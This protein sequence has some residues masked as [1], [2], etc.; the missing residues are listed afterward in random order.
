MYNASPC[1]LPAEPYDGQS[2][3]DIMHHDLWV[4][5][6]VPSAANEVDGGPWM[7]GSVERHARHI[8]IHAVIPQLRFARGLQVDVEVA[9]RY[10][11]LM[12]EVA[13]YRLPRV[14]HL[15][16]VCCGIVEARSEGQRTVILIR[17]PIPRGVV[18]PAA[19]SN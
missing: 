3:R 10:P 18:R 13:A 8:N 16:A 4:L 7:L 17:R 19:A 1:A 9:P 14:G 6:H 12:M 5:G 15:R 11:R 2:A